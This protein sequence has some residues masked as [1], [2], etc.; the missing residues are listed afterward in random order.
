[1]H[2]IVYLYMGFPSRL[3]GAFRSQM[4]LPPSVSTECD[5]VRDIAVQEF[6][7]CLTMRCPFGE[8]AGEGDS[9]EQV[10]WGR[11][12][13][14]EG[15]Q[16]QSLAFLSPFLLGALGS[17][18]VGVCVRVNLTVRFN[19]HLACRILWVH[20]VYY[21]EFIFLMV[22]VLLLSICLLFH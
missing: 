18:G 5:T 8:R 14:E 11:C 6:G 22:C 1:M 10:S 19:Q 3:S 21:S 4:H 9:S 7:G 17:W 13:G 15:P 12:S 16:K 2:V 20:G